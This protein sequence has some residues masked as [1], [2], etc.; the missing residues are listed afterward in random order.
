MHTNNSKID[1]VIPAYYPDDKIKKLVEML[2]RQTVAVSQVIIV[3]TVPN[4]MATDSVD[5]ILYNAEQRIRDC[6]KIEGIKVTT[7]KVYEDEFDHGGTRNRGALLASDDC[8]FLLFMTQDAVPMDDRLI[9]SLVA[10]FDDKSVA[11][12]Y[13]RQM[14]AENS[15]ISEQFTRGFNYPD[16]DQ[17]K[18]LE[19]IETMGIK[20]FFCSNVCAMYRRSV[21]I[22]LGQFIN[23][24]IFN[25]DMVFANK[26][27]KNGYKIAYA[28][29][30]K[31][32]H[33]HEYT[34]MQQYRRNFDLAVSQV[35]NPQAFSGISSESEG[36]KYV[37]A[38]F[39]YFLKAKKPLE[40]VPFG[41]KCVY[42]YMGYRK[43]KKVLSLSKKEIYKATS[44]ARF[45]EKLP[46]GN[47]ML[48]YVLRVNH[49]DIKE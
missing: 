49:I 39:L 8:E 12:A 32:I 19:D 6:E 17:V 18:S 7:S 48:E 9:K 36:L 29:D 27:L 43:G 47:E 44:N 25:E 41:I 34:G 10:K 37:K 38:A 26:L 42:K 46:V 3:N 2:S 15:S 30:A 28:K 23:R 35:L 14:P 40:I 13:A 4:A 45:F 22:S 33:T 11:A 5:T 24:T 16:I 21:F 31:V 1:V 20:A